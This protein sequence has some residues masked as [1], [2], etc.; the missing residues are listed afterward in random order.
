MRNPEIMK[1]SSRRY[2]E[3]EY[4]FKLYPYDL[5]KIGLT[6]LGL[7]TFLEAGFKPDKLA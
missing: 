7:K 1:N 3:K 4:E 6:Q 5:S 2:Q